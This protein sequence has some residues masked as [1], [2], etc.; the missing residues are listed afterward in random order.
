MLIFPVSDL[1]VYKIKKWIFYFYM[2]IWKF[3][4]LE[5]EVS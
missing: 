4:S 5:N 3:V 1:W 2:N